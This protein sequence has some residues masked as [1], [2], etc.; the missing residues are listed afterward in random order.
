MLVEKDLQRFRIKLVTQYESHP[1]AFFAL[2]ALLFGLANGLAA[3]QLLE[4]APQ[5]KENLGHP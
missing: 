1:W 2:A 5:P 4:P 3:A